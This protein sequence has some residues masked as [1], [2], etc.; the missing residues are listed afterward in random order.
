MGALPYPSGEHASQL[1]AHVVRRLLQHCTAVCWRGDCIQR[2]LRGPC[3]LAPQ[4]SGPGATA[5]GAAS[6]VARLEAVSLCSDAHNE[7]TSSAP[8]RCAHQT[9]VRNVCATKRSTT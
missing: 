2:R 5:G 4:L 1:A 6:A 3:W 9:G 8:G 7:A